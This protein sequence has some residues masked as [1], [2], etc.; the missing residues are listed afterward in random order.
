MS[1]IEFIGARL[2]RHVDDIH[3]LRRRCRYRHKEIPKK[4]PGSARR[5]SIPRKDLLDAQYSVLKWLE[6]LVQLH[7]AAHGFVSGRS[8]V[9]NALPHLGSWVLVTMDLEAWY[10]HVSVEKIRRALTKQLENQAISRLSL[11]ADINLIVDLCTEKGYLP[12]GAPTSPILANIVARWLDERLS[13]ML[14]AEWRYSRFADDLS[15][16]SPTPVRGEALGALVDKIIYTIHSC[17][18]RVAVRKTK[19]RKQWQRQEV[20][21]VIT[22]G[23]RPAVSRQFRRTIRAVEHNME[24]GRETKWTMEQL[25]SAEAFVRMV[26]AYDEADRG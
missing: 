10:D 6:P 9:T 4:R 7:P 2:G 5:V 21:G 25:R 22:N 23:D 18:F 17:G 26:E 15:F 14:P 11:R 19:I 12:T 13:R 16:S 1:L 8:I 24:K 3:E 20:T